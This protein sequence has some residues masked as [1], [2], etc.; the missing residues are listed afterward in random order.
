MNKYYN[1]ANNWK[2]LSEKEF[3][4]FTNFI[5]YSNDFLR[6]KRDKLS[7]MCKNICFEFNYIDIYIDI[8]DRKERIHFKIDRND[9]LTCAA[10]EDTTQYHK[11]N[12]YCSIF[13]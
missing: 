7:I 12:K 9:R 13:R 3:N 6:E 11:C 5:C 8:L 2:N 1:I 4:D 10:D